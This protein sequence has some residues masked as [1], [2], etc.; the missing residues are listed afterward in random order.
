MSNS[1]LAK[2]S[3]MKTKLF[4]SLVLSSAF[5]AYSAFAQAATGSAISSEDTPEVVRNLSGNATSLQALVRT[6]VN[7]V[8]GF[9]G[10]VTI[11]MI[12]YGGFL[13]VTS[14]GNEEA[15]GKGKK[16][17]IYA[18]LGIVIIVLSGVIVNAVLQAGTGVTP[19]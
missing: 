17:L 8:L 12:I 3:S 19:Q 4:S 9:L 2:A 13:M 7:Y 5:S 6:M 18:I 10:F 16:I 15:V 1:F 11:L 14:Q